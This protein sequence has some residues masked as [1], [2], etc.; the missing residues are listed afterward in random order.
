MKSSLIVSDAA[1][2]EENVTDILDYQREET[3]QLF[4][5]NLEYP[6]NEDE[7]Q[8]FQRF[9][10]YSAG[11]LSGFFDPSFWTRLV[12]QEA[13]VVPPIRHAAIAIGALNKSLENAPGPGLKV[14]I[15]QN[16]DKK[17]HA[18]AVSQY[19]RAIQA[20]NNYITASNDPQLRTALVACLL[21]VCFETFQGSLASAVQ[22]TYGGL[23]ILRSYYQGKPSSRPR[24]STKSPAGISSKV[25]VT[26]KITQGL[27]SRLGCDNVSKSRAIAMHLE[28]YLDTDSLQSES[29]ENVNT[30]SDAF[31]YDLS[32]KHHVH[33]HATSG[34]SF[35]QGRQRPILSVPVGEYSGYSAGI[36]SDGTSESTSNEEDSIMP[37]GKSSIL[38]TS[39]YLRKASATS[40]LYK[41]AESPVITAPRKDPSTL[42]NSLVST[43]MIY[44]PP[45][46]GTHTPSSSLVPSIQIS[47]TTQAP[48]ISQGVTNTRKRP[49][50][51]ASRSPTPPPLHNDFAIEEILIQTFVRLDG[52]GLFFGMIP[53]I[54]P[55]IWDIHKIW[56]LPIPTSFPDFAS[57][58]RCWDFLMDRALQF[59]R[60][61]SFNRAYAPRNS[62]PP[63]Q[64]GS[65][66]KSHLN[67]LDAFEAAFRPILD[68]A[69][70]DDGAVANPPALL[71]S[72]YQRITVI[73][74]A[75]VPNDSEMVYDS[76]LSDFKYI[77][78][79]CAL[80]ISSPSMAQR[81]PN[82]RFTF[83]VGIVPP[84]HIV[85]TKCRDPIVRR[86]AI[87]L[88]F[89]SPRQE[90]MWDGILTARIGKWMKRCEEDGLGEPP[91]LDSRQ[92]S[93]SQASSLGERGSGRFSY[94]SPPPVER[95]SVGG[96]E[97]GK[98]ISDA[99]NEAVGKRNF[100]KNEREHAVSSTASRPR[101]TTGAKPNK[102]E[103]QQNGGEVHQRGWMVPEENRVRLMVVDFHF[104]ERYVKVKCQKAL[105]GVDGKKE[106]RE[107]VIAW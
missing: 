38:S 35:S 78:R 60:R 22:Q 48:P 62:D 37:Y 55:L 7:S 67:Q 29:E 50:T 49:L 59:F 31:I 97:D 92:S 19:L 75:G 76:Y 93:I 63:E 82:P 98:S 65:E 79:T 52:Q 94:P 8:Y 46:T 72:L 36:T 6:H 71:L 2:S 33:P 41:R 23:K 21:F 26:G 15:I 86:E 85:A 11:E 17:H 43:P 20:L 104:P 61:T 39:D 53:G 101:G 83:E 90:G 12:L 16:I 88:L 28:E 3:L 5:S 107:T 95:G 100:G 14:N 91:L 66:L 68:Q 45:S 1:N 51:L 84:L 32:V 96:W 74:L 10:E 34:T 69:I 105:P 103:V 42:S 18:A 77:V 87:S 102:N 4:P 56:H 47:S 89:A 30:L 9:I 54:P 99:V 27:L 25:T 24:I 80:L 81:P 44:T 106:G 70:G 13:H 40:C 57:A 64:I 73:M 58:H